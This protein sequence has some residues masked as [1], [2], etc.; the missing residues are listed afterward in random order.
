MRRFYRCVAL[1]DHWFARLLRKLYQGVDGFSVLAPRVLTSPMLALM[2]AI[3][4]TYCF[5]RRVFI[6]EPQFKVY[7][8]RVGRLS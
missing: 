1:S 7:Y 4:T 6:A 8:T 3:R 5:L 2:I